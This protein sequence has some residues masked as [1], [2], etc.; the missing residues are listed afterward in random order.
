MTLWT[1]ST[2]IT[3]LLMCHD[4]NP[5]SENIKPHNIIIDEPL[6][7]SRFGLAVSR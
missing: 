7:V 4:V 5:T 2:M 3:Y 1:L 6:L